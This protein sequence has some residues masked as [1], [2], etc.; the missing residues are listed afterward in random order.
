MN[1]RRAAVKKENAE[2]NDTMQSV[3]RDDHNEETES[4]RLMTADTPRGTSLSQNHW[5]AADT[6]PRT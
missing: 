4:A 3:E 5:V 2:E 6:R 1:G